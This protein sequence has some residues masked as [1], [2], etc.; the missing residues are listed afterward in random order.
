MKKIHFLGFSALLVILILFVGCPQSRDDQ[1]SSVTTVFT[2]SAPAE[3][4][5]GP[6]GGG[7][8]VPY[9]D[10]DRFI[11]TL[12]QISMIE[13]ECDDTC[14]APVADT[15]A[16]MNTEA[17]IFEGSVDVDLMDLN[18]A[19]ETLGTQE[20]EAGVYHQIRLSI[21][22]PRLYLAA[23]PETPI[24]DVHLT[25]ESRLFAT[26][27]FEF[28]GGETNLL[29]VD[30]GGVRLKEQGNG[31]YL[32]TPQLRVAVGDDAD[33][34]VESLDETYVMGAIAKVQARQNYVSVDVE[35]GNGRVKVNYENAEIFL[36][37]DAGDTGSGTPR[38]LRKGVVIDAVGTMGRGATLEATVISILE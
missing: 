33:D 32:L 37:T 17:I 2:S 6:Q 25:A 27:H 1:K 3:T 23:D 14:E 8:D 16:K 31:T 12:T 22:D 20:I 15:E 11:V 28:D 7:N 24:T 30:F 4:K 19:A 10:I 29:L 13:G 26:G 38:D 9:D 5:T 18:G 36:P 34:E 35:G 21:E